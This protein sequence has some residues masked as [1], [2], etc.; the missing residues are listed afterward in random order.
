MG[1]SS[2]HDEQLDTHF[3]A[4]ASIESSNLPFESADFD[5]EKF[6]KDYN[7]D[8]N[9][10]ITSRYVTCPLCVDD[11]MRLICASFTGRGAALDAVSKPAQEIEGG[12]NFDTTSSRYVTFP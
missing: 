1:S 7:V 3:F 6:M 9:V 12:E 4:D 11:K 5:W 8:E 10:D 2:S